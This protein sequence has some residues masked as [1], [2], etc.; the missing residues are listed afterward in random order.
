METQYFLDIS[1]AITLAEVEDIYVP[2]S[3]GAVANA[4]W[5]AEDATIQYNSVG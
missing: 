2:W 1:K 4:P 3:R 5:G